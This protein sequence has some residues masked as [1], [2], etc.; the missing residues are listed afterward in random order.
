MNDC[1]SMAERL[2]Q[3]TLLP[4]FTASVDIKAD[5]ERTRSIAAVCAHWLEAWNV[6]LTDNLPAPHGCFS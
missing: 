5:T 1:F 6:H 4:H 2:E 3:S